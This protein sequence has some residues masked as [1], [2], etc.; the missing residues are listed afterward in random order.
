MRVIVESLSFI[1][2]KLHT[3]NPSREGNID[4]IKFK[5]SAFSF[6]PF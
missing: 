2:I 5:L 4:R 6:K 1:Y 3:P